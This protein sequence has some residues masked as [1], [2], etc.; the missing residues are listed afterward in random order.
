MSLNDFQF[1]V[2]QTGNFH[3]FYPDDQ[4]RHVRLRGWWCHDR[5][6]AKK[7]WNWWIELLKRDWTWN[8]LKVLSK[9]KRVQSLE[10]TKNGIFWKHFWPILL[11]STNLKIRNRK[12][13]KSYFCCF[14]PGS[15][16]N[17]QNPMNLRSTSVSTY[18][19]IPI[20]LP[21]GNKIVK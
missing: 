2:N 17:F 18:F 20:G 19:Q 6:N 14:L 8:F 10:L 13:H 21:T 11:R 16:R 4:W 1:L 15:L 7:R 9:S 3:F 12:I 5:K